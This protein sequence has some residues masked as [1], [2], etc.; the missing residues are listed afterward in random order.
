MARG[1]LC[2][3]ANVAGANCVMGRNFRGEFGRGDLYR[4]EMAARPEN[5]PKRT[6]RE[7]KFSQNRFPNEQLKI[8]ENSNEPHFSIKRLTSTKRI[9]SDYWHYSLSVH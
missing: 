9:I 2:H 1:E 5:L 8:P 4:G 7:N 3:G 6:N